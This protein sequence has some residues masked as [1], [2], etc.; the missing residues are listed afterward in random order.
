[1]DTRGLHKKFVVERVDNSD[2]PGGKH[3]GCTYYVLDLTHDEVAF[4]M[5][6]TLAAA[7]RSTR[8]NL[9]DDLMK[10]YTEFTEHDHGTH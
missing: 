1:M 7:Y 5:L 9:A 4:S 8:P 6:P 10:M 3:S 2:L